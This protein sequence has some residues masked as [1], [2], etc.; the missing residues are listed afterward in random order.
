MITGAGMVVRPPRGVTFRAQGL[1]PPGHRENVIN[2]MQGPR[3]N[4]FA[5]TLPYTHADSRLTQEADVL[6]HR[7]VRVV[8]GLGLTV[9]A[10]LTIYP[11][12]FNHVSTEAV[13]NAPVVTLRAPF[14][15][16]VTAPS[17]GISTSVALDD[18]LVVL[19]RDRVD[20][21]IIGDLEA[22]LVAISGRFNAVAAQRT[23]LRALRD[24]LSRRATMHA[25]WAAAW[26]AARETEAEA[27]TAA[28][29]ARLSEAEAHRDR[30]RR[31][32]Q[33]GALT[34]VALDS[35]ETD[36]RVAE[37]L[38]AAER[39]AHVRLSVARQALQDGVPLNEGGEGQSVILSRLDDLD[40]Q[41]AALD[42][43]HASLDA[44]RQALIKQ[45]AFHEAILRDREVFTPRAQFAGIVWEVSP[46]VGTPVLQGDKLVRLL[47]CTKR[48]VEV[49]IDERHFERI[50]PGAM[51]RIRLKG[52]QHWQ[53]AEITA[54]I[55]SGSRISRPTPG[56]V[57][58]AT[59]D[60]QLNVFLGLPATDPRDPTV[61]RAFCDVGRAAEV[62]FERRHGTAQDALSRLATAAADARRAIGL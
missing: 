47:D 26:L 48:V 45:I 37:S 55:G 4:Q 41:L 57:T 33:S 11:S 21:N 36:A 20:E 10:G 1:R 44:E 12:V 40:L 14:D 59:S 61:A 60:G 16:T 7:F 35:A 32:A 17:P 56:G 28:A 30:Q 9:A 31:L 23:A 52:S 46:P 43:D 19:S 3:S 2:F 8:A 27:R 50:A 58:L 53:D 5:N 38:R 54:V 49:A 25:E 24:S 42:K 15:G 39:A 62:R 13:V 6:G 51:A 18:P 34:R 29:S 22:R